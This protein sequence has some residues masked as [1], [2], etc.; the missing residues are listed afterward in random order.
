ML[1]NVLLGVQIVVC[2]ILVLVILLQRSEG[3]ALG[4]GG[5]GGG[6]FMTARGAGDLL[7]RTTS[8][9]AGAFFALCLGLTL[10]AA[11]QRNASSLTERLDVRPM[12]PGALA[13]PQQPQQPAT[14]TPGLLPA[15][16]RAT[17]PAAALPLEAPTPSVRGPLPATA[18]GVTPAPAARPAVRPAPA[19]AQPAPT[20]PAPATTTPAPTPAP[21]TPAPDPTP[22]PAT[23]APTPAPTTPPAT[24]TPPTP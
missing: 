10:L 8:I 23:P 1:L 5:G 14:T 16:P 19:A 24:E 6:N 12:D 7:T 2:I 11:S 18:P 13:R 9:A 17:A 4:M 21:T 3:G 20:T 22:A 15:T